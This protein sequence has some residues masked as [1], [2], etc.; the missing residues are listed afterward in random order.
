M[1]DAL[2]HIARLSL[3]FGRVNRATLHEDGVTP[4][5]DTDHT[6]MLGLL[7][8]HIAGNEAAGLNLDMGRLAALALVHDLV[9]VYAGDTNTAGG[10]T[11][12]QRA[13]K[14]QRELAA[15]RR[16]F[17]ELG[18]PDGGVSPVLWWLHDYET[19]DTREAR[20]LRY[21]D[22]ITPKLTH[23]LNGNAVLRRE[24]WTVERLRERHR[25]QGAELAERYPEFAPVLGPLF[26]AACA[27]SEEALAGP[28][29]ASMLT[30]CT[31]CTWAGEHA[32]RPTCAIGWSVACL[33]DT[34]QR[35][36]DWK[37]ANLDREGRPR[38]GATYCP[39]FSA[40][41]SRG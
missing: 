31:R 24:G 3:A 27:A 1:P 34:F 41:V 15:A 6:V 23:A 36:T 18:R 8:L 21:L 37:I 39:S 29:P 40:E 35:L 5:T 16:L 13:E 7:A 19:G 32:G 30:N 33:P 22:K 28:P 17:A 25:A 26:D 11:P 9:E 2:L 10:L 38:A 4:E 12:E 14:T 20:F